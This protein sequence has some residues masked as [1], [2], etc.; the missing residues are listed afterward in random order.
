MLKKGFLYGG[1]K[2]ACGKRIL[3][4]VKQDGAKAQPLTGAILS[5]PLNNAYLPG[6]Q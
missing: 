4:E 2:I 1:Q 3:D 5:W 6:L